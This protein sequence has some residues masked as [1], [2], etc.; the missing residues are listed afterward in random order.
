MSTTATSVRLPENIA[1][2]LDGLAKTLDRSKTYLIR[3]AV[4]EYLEEYEDYLVAL[5]RLNDKDD[6]IISSKE[7]RRKI[8]R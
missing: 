2:K 4:E 8:G 1:K 5:R 7:L 3:K 6:R